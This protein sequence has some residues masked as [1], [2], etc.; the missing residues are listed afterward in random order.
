MVWALDASHA[1]C[2]R[3]RKQADI[4]SL[5]RSGELRKFALRHGSVTLTGN[6]NFSRQRKMKKF[7]RMKQI[8]PNH[9]VVDLVATC[10]ER[11]ATW[12]GCWQKVPGGKGEDECV[13]H[14]ILSGCGDCWGVVMV[15]GV[16]C[17]E[18]R[19]GDWAGDSIK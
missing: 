14:E 8:D 5:L 19:T 7:R 11:T 16:P 10:R 2:A 18:D 17:N 1:K 6:T 4:V 12:L 13:D 3:R 15:I 9:S